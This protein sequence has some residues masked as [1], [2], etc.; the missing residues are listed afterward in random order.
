MKAATL[1]GYTLIV[2]GLFLGSISILSAL[3]SIPMFL[4]L[5]ASETYSWGF[6]IGRVL[7]V[8]LLLLLAKVAISKGKNLK[9]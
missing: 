5:N 1:G 9:N 6:V 8:V 4:E 7:M 3:T 2:I